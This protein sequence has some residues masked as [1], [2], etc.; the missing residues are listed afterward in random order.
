MGP[1]VGM[2]RQV[3]LQHSL[4]PPQIPHLLVTIL[5]SSGSFAAAST[6]VVAVGLVAEMLG[7]EE[8]EW[9]NRSWSLLEDTKQMEMDQSFAA[10]VGAGAIALAASG[11]AKALGWRG[12]VGS[13][14]MGPAAGLFAHMV[15]RY[16]IKREQFKW[17]DCR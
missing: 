1:I 5:R 4:P 11:Y 3:R 13:S 16:G 12:Q 2:A 17:E 6:G 9:R 8:V 10:G 7:R 15:W 14:G